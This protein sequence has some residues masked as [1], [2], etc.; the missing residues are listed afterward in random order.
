M[1]RCSRVIACTTGERIEALNIS[2]ELAQELHTMLLA[3]F[4]ELA[5][6]SVGVEELTGIPSRTM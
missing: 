2:R 3:H 1:R 6:G 5:I 4:D